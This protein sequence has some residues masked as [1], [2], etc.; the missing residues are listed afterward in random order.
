MKLKQRVHRSD[1]YSLRQKRQRKEANLSRQAVL[2]EQAQRELGD[3]IRGV[4]TP[5]VRSF[6]SDVAQD[7]S[8]DV[9]AAAGD[10]SKSQA[11]PNQPPPSPAD[12]LAYAN[13]DF[14]LDPQSLHSSLRFSR[15]L[16]E[17]LPSTAKDEKDR[18][19]EAAVRQQWE[20]QD[21]TA[22]EA[23]R[24]I[25]NL[26]MGSGMH[27]TKK[28]FERVISKLGRHNTDAVLKPKT[29]A[30]STDPD[31]PQPTP[32]AGPDT[33]SSEVQIGVLTAKIRVLADRYQGGARHDKA[34]K[35]NLRL[36]LHR[37]QKLLKYMERK[38]R[39]GER[40][41]NM[42]ETLG[43]TPATWKGEIAVQ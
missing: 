3:P 43:L 41:T 31:A 20:S 34:N 23:V 37:R 14:G 38:E 27:R 17:P 16:T 9:N 29:A 1:A 42:I 2:K 24:R 13:L 40:W 12:S 18:E 28:N 30:Q 15:K 39:G 22:T 7:L 11:S 21:Q 26:S 10:L 19:R 33:G 4:E 25:V 32:R 8:R 5:F 35:R 36:L 6:D